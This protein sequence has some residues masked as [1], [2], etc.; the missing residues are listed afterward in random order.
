MSWCEEWPFSRV[1]ARTGEDNASARRDYAAILSYGMEVV[2]FSRV[3]VVI[4][5]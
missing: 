1:G 2:N 5:Q 4:Q 3:H